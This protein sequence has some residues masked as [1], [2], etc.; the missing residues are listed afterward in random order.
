MRAQKVPIS[1]SEKIMMMRAFFI[2]LTVA[3]GP[4]DSRGQ[5]RGIDQ[6]FQPELLGPEVLFQLVA[7]RI[8]LA[9]LIK[10]A[11]VDAAQING[12]DQNG[13]KAKNYKDKTEMR[14]FRFIMVRLRSP[15][16]FD[17]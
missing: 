13:R 17:L 3:F 9:K 2:L 16:V 11:V 1:S 5:R 15:K 4:G 10:E 6:A 7:F 12:C 14:H 8:V